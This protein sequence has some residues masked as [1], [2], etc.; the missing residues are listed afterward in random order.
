MSWLFD[1]ALELKNAKFS[2]CSLAPPRDQISPNFWRGLR[3]II[4]F[5]LTYDSWWLRHW[6]RNNEA[7]RILRRSRR[8]FPFLRRRINP[9][10]MILHCLSH[11]LEICWNRPKNLK[12]TT[13]ICGGIHRQ[14]IRDTKLIKIYISRKFNNQIIC[15]KALFSSLLVGGIKAASHRN[16][17]WRTVKS[18]SQ[19]RLMNLCR[20][21]I[22]KSFILWNPLHQNTIFKK[23]NKGG[24]A[25]FWKKWKFYSG[26]FG[27]FQTVRLC[28]IHYPPIILK[29]I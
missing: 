25:G 26:H 11:E 6:L 15:S 4:S 20:S 3:Q 21:N 12:V 5:H 22:R 8:F 19:T 10:K 13:T 28:L 29:S 27:S 18:L 7:N 2:I 23:L 24:K 16:I 9:R 14:W 17:W 1:G